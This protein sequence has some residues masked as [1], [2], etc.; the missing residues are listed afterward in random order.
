MK[1]LV[2]NSA[3]I[4]ASTLG[5]ESAAAHTVIMSVAFLCFLLGDVGSSLAQAFLPAYATKR[6][7]NAR[8]QTP[9]QTRSSK[10]SRAAIGKKETQTPPKGGAKGGAALFDMAAARPA[11]TSI[12][13]TCWAISGV[14]VLCSSLILT[15]GQGAFTSDPGVQA[16]MASVLPC[17]ALTLALHST[18]VTLEGLLLV[19]RKLRVLCSTYL[20]V[21]LA[22]AGLH[23]L[24]AHLVKSPAFPGFQ[25][26]GGL[27]ALWATY[28]L[29][30]ASR[31][32][33][34][35]LA[36]GLAPGPRNL[37]SNLVGKVR[38]G[39]KGSGKGL[40][41]SPVAPAL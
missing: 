10:G 25:A 21:G 39:G 14:A 29:F 37:L 11:V 18:A 41:A 16:R 19:Q 20:A 24:I 13:R 22:C 8:D 9:G 6:E 2:H 36:T 7:G 33:V 3:S 5:G 23:Q 28:V 27:V 26:P 30:Q 12:L 40:E 32:A 38:P 4:T 35:A 34:F 15:L 17:T 1:L 31:I